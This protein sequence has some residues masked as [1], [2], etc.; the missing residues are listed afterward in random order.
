MTQNNKQAKGHSDQLLPDSLSINISLPA[1]FGRTDKHAM[2]RKPMSAKKVEHNGVTW[3]DIENPT[4]Q[5]L[6]R[7]AQEYSFHPVHIEESLFKS[8]QPQLEKEAG[9]LFL[10]LYLPSFNHIASRILSSQI[11][12]FLGKNYVVTIHDESAPEIRRWLGKCEQDD[13][14]REQFFKKSSGF[15]LYSIIASILGSTTV[16]IQRILEE[17]DE[18]EYSVFDDNTSDVH[19]IGLLRQKIIRLRKV[20]ASFR[21][22][23]NELAAT[24]NDFSGEHLA[25]HYRNNAYTNEKL[26]EL[27]EESKETVEIYKDADFTVSTEK[28]NE[29]LAVLTLI[30]TF[31]IPATV[32]GTFYGMNI[33]LPGGVQTGAWAFLGDYT[34]LIVLFAASALP[35]L[36]MFLLFKKKKWL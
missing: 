12:V 36:F 32:I 19:R 24:I 35:G 9:Y 5:E 23:L 1:L 25:R 22:V 20:I 10:L 4:S 16:I 11:G 33:P 30:F 21:A 7:L 15:L 26:W 6:A 34:T 8:Q 29:I 31:T 2:D 27:I 17:L 14:Y 28:T 13:G 18:I 3:L